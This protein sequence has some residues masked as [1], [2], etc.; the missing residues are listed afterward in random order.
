MDRKLHRFS[1]VL[2]AMLLMLLSFASCSK[3][4]D[5]LNGGDDDD[6]NDIDD[7]TE[8]VEGVMTDYQLSG[9]VKDV[10]GSPI[11]GVTIASGTSTV[12]TN[13]F[14]FFEMS[15]V[16]MVDKQ[17][18]N[19][20]VVRFSKDGYFDVVR[21]MNQRSD[22]SGESWEVV[23]CKKESNDF[24]AV[25]SYNSSTAQTLQ[26]GGM[27][28]EMP[29]NGYQVDGSGAY[30]VGKVKTDMLYLNPNNDV[31]AEMM[32]GGDLAAVR[33][34]GSSAALVSYGMAD[35][36]MQS[37]TGE[38]LQLKKG[39][40]AKL[41]FP[42]PG[43]MTDNLPSSIPLWSFNEQ[44]GLWEEEGSAMLQG[45]VYV[46][47]VSHFSWVNLDYPEK[48]AT[49]YGYVKDDAGNPL[50]GVRLNIGQLLSA[51]V[52]NSEGYYCQDVPANTAFS[53]SVKPKYYGNYG[54]V[55]P[56]QV[57]P[58]APGKERQVDI[59]LPH[60]VRV[61][62]KVV[63]SYGEGLRASVCVEVDTWRIDDVQTD[64]DGN[65]SIYIPEG[66]KG[67]AVV[68]ARTYGGQDASENITID[69]EDVEVL[70]KVEGGGG[71]GINMI[72]IHSD[73]LGDADW[74]VPISN[75]LM[76]G[77]IILDDNLIVNPG[78]DT[79]VRLGVN[80]SGYD[81]NKSKYDNGVMVVA[82]NDRTQAVFSTYEGKK[83]ECTV[84]RKDNSFAFALDVYGA[85]T[86]NQ[87]ERY[88]EDARLTG[89]N[90]VYNL[91]AV[92][93]TLRNVK[94]SAIGFPSF[95]PQLTVNASLVMQI[96]E[97]P[98]FG[99]GG[100]VYYNGGSNDYLTL[101]NAAAKQGL[102]NMGEDNEDGS[103]SVTYYS[104]EKKALIS[105]EYDPSATGITDDT[106]WEDADEKAPIYMM[107]L[108]GVSRDMLEAMFADDTRSRVGGKGQLLKH[109]LSFLHKKHRRC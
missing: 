22:A 64:A 84:Q 96:T 62:G 10:D 23:M 51:V 75:D 94:P 20:S 48:Q 88:D 15:K 77:V 9:F 53:I 25:N 37:E 5:L 35:I 29:E 13:S 63:N 46:G 17:L 2:V 73:K 85:Y 3:L 78:E 82:E 70:L 109:F 101:K 24:T 98:R 6:D 38:K 104:A 44:T 7:P 8:V 107:V 80:I 42:V 95:T 39:C 86:N 47:E 97:S 67:K 52:T 71:A 26:A 74:P 1:F 76:G 56:K 27:K 108:D 4:Q 16:N 54:S 58:I 11:G 31:F 68:R 91:L 99:K 41:T 43:G 32:P 60:L 28:I 30:Y 90:L 49:V 72:H 33:S 18:G 12:S 89:E 81:K 14:G 45:N 79:A 34:D 50:P 87:T 61:Y 105:I 59:V 93:K 83:V 57:S 55:A 21:S 106:T 36:N 102:T 19:R 40:K 92:G 65:F 100:V 66:V 103:M 69:K